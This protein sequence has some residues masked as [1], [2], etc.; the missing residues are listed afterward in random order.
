MRISRDLMIIGREE[1]INMFTQAKT[2]EGGFVANETA[3]KE[4]REAIDRLNKEI[5]REYLKGE[6]RF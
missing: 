3:T 2:P 5:L 1:N 6:N 4:V